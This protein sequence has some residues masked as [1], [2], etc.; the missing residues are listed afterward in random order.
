MDSSRASIS[1]TRGD[2]AQH[3]DCDLV[4]TVVSKLNLSDP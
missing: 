3:T 4:F 1:P 2:L